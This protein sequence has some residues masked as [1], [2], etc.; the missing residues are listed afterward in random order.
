MRTNYEH[1]STISHVVR[2]G[3]ALALVC[4]AGL[5]CGTVF[6]A[7][8]IDFNGIADGT[9]VSANNPY[10]GILNLQAATANLILN[11]QTWNQVWTES[12]IESGVLAG[13]I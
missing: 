7:L 5:D 6:A 1:R 4:L 9:P 13:L 3:L 11:G 10:G 8:T 2:C 12:T